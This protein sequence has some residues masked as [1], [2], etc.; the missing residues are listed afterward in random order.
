MLEGFGAHHGW[1]AVHC[2]QALDQLKLVHDD[3]LRVQLVKIAQVHT[4]L[5]QSPTATLRSVIEMLRT[6]GLLPV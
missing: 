5:T 6:P 3:A 4:L 1:D 2:R